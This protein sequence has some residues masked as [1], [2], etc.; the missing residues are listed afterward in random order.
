MTGERRA[1]AIVDLRA[2]R[3]NFAEARRRAEGREVVA[4]VKADAYGH[5]AVPVARA[6]AEAGCRRFAVATVPEAVA[7]RDAGRDEPILV[8]GGVEDAAEAEAAGRLG[9]TPVVHGDAHVARL[10][11]AAARTPIEVEVEVD[12]GMRRMGAS[13]E[14][15]P[16]LLAAVSAAPGLR[17]QGVYTHFARADEADL[18]P[19]L[20]QIAL[21]RAVLD[22]ARERGVEP[23]AVHAANSAALL[24]GKELADALPGDAAVRPELMLYGVCPAVHLDVSLVPAMTLIARVAQVHPLRAGE[25]VGYSSHHRASVDTRVAT[26][27]VGYADGIPI[28]ASNRGC[29][30]LGGRRAPIVGRVSMDFVTVDVGDARVAV[31]DDAIVFG[32]R[33]DAQLPVDEAAIAAGTI[34]YEL[35]VGVGARVPRVYED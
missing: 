13:P 17:L 5:G 3:A 21:F 22:A 27:S 23:A 34:S 30:L 20:E 19:S 6:L 8:F 16:G 10:A 14:A 35:L 1:R 18:A 15:A 24:A 28:A 32:A 26:L 12:T 31:G 33:G 7:L 29:V 11:E 25:T 9:L 4:V 2:V